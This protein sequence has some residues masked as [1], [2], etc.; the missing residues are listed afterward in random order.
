MPMT[1]AEFTRFTKDDIE[2]NIAVVKAA[3]I[4]TQ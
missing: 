4:P 1:Q 2:A 3:K